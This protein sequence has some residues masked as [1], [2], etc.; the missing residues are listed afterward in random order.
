M[1]TRFL[2]ANKTY[3]HVFG[4]IF[5]NCKPSISMAE[6]D[7]DIFGDSDSDQSFHGFTAEELNESIPREDISV[8]EYS[9]ESENE[10][11]SE[12]ENGEETDDEAELL[13]AG[14]MS[15]DNQRG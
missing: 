7:H 11:N 6:V 5:C 3:I 4:F 2:T 9:S 10:G 15:R 8:E 13:Q 14:V 1:K 12:E